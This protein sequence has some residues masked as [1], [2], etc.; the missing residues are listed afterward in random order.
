V[1]KKPLSTKKNLTAL[2]PLRK[3]LADSK[4]SNPFLAR[5]TSP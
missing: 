3:K 5:I 2:P 4:A 1:I